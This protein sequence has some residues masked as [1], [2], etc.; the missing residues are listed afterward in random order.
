MFAPRHLQ[1]AGASAQYLDGLRIVDAHAAARI[2]TV[3]ALAVLLAQPARLV[4]REVGLVVSRIW[5][6]PLCVR[7]VHVDADIDTGHVEHAENAHRHAPAFER[8]IDRA[9]GRAFEHHALGLP[10]ITFHHAIADEAIADLREHWRLAQG[11]RQIHDGTQ[12]GCRGF[13]GTHD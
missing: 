11:F 4:Q 10:R 5:R 9:R 1:L 3:V 6:V 8:A 2:V 13:R 7:D 12:D